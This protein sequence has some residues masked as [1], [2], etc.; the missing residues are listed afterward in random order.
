MG[1]FEQNLK[2]RSI[3]KT[4]YLRCLPW[5]FV[6]LA[7][8]LS[9]TTNA[10]ELDWRQYSA[11]IHVHSA[12]SNGEYEI[13]ELARLAVERNIDVLVLTDSFLTTVTYSVWPFDRIGFDGI[14]RMVRPGVRNHLRQ[15]RRP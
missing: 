5:T 3:G 10:S 9:S 6:F 7:F 13:S 14:N 4:T 15:R 11:A 8:A 1:S 12:F 2:Q